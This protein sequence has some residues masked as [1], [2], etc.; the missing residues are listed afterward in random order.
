MAS[1][2]G[3]VNLALS[4]LGISKEIA[5]IETEKSIEAETARRFYD[6][7]LEA[8]LRDFP[9][10]FAGRFA[11]LGLVEETPTTEWNYSYRYPSDALYLRRILSGIRNDNRQARVPYKILSD[12][13]GLLL[14]TDQETAEIEYTV[15]ATDPQFYPSDFVVAFSFYL[16]HLMAPR[17]TGGDQF[18][19][20]DRA[21]QNYLLEISRAVSRSS[22]EQQDE[23]EPQSEF[24]RARE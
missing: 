11:N 10:P 20:G 14:Y 8:T 24:I 16:A 2:V 23:E 17:V 18:K 15:R 5:N 9:W 1:K 21:Q 7:A 6:T 3:I 19:L 13:S 12:S 4:H 22:N